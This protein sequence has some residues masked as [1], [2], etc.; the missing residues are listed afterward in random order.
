MDEIVAIEQDRT[1]KRSEF[2]KLLSPLLSR[3]AIC[4]SIGDLIAHREW[5]LTRDSTQKARLEDLLEGL[6]CRST[7]GTRFRDFDHVVQSLVV[8]ETVMAVGDE[9]LWMVKGRALVTHALISQCLEEGDHRVG[10]RVAER[11]YAVEEPVRPAVP[12]QTLA[13]NGVDGVRR[14]ATR[15]LADVAIPNAV[16]RIENLVTDFLSAAFDDLQKVFSDHT[17]R[18]N[19]VGVFAKLVVPRTLKPNQGILIC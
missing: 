13:E 18:A 8:L 4:V 1:R 15:I 10:V 2:L 14:L 9:N 16:H 11:I 12:E 5:D 19:D 17:G 7:S 3:C 6:Q